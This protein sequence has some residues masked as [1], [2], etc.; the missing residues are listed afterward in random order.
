MNKLNE[1]TLPK[2]PPKDVYIN[3]YSGLEYVANNIGGIFRELYVCE[4][5]R[6]DSPGIIL[7]ISCDANGDFFTEVVK[8]FL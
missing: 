3:L 7:R 1:K 6:Q 8:E 4:E 5:V 2:T